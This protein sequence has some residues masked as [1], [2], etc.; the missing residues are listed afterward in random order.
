MTSDF[1]KQTPIAP[2]N[3]KPLIPE[4]ADMN[5]ITDSIV[6]S[7]AALEAESKANLAKL[8]ADE[9]QIQC[10]IARAEIADNAAKAAERAIKKDFHDNVSRRAQEAEARKKEDRQRAVL[11]QVVDFTAS[12]GK[13]A[14]LIDELTSRDIREVRLLRA[15]LDELLISLSKP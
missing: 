6:A 9:Y 3:L 12:V 15:A 4:G 11:L 14:L 7:K 13:A 1:F 8:A 10:R 2:S 5:Q